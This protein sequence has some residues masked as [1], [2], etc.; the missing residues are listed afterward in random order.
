MPRE[1][2]Q[3]ELQE[4][5][6]QVLALG[7]MAD[8]AIGRAVEA[9][10]MRH[11]MTARQVVDDDDLLDEKRAEIERQALL[12]ITRQQP[13]ATDL[14]LIAGA[15]TLASELER[16]GDYAEGIAK[17]SLDLQG[18]PTLKPMVI[19][20][21]MADKVRD[22]LNRSLDAY[23]ARDADVSRRIWAEDDQIDDL[24]SQ[25]YGELVALMAANPGSI[26]AATRLLWVSHNLERIADRVT[27]ICENTIFIVEGAVSEI[28]VSVQ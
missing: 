15:M 12:L 9:L 8:K 10:T 27:N 16:I 25:M 28:R 19:I 2:F 24:Y 4:L 14:R 23:V 21:R 11:E 7:S 26:E 3:R 18:E 5:Q 6:D 20:P 17:I 1:T 22:M 13:V